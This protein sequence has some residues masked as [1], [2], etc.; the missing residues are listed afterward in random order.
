MR[1][2]ILALALAAVATPTVA[3]D[4]SGFYAGAT[5]TGTHVSGPMDAHTPWN[6]YA[7]FDLQG[8]S[9]TG[10]GGGV[11]LGF[12]VQ[13]S[14]M[15]YG[16]EAGWG[17]AN[18]SA[19]TTT[20]NLRPDFPRFDRTL[21]SVITLTPRVG[22][23]SGDSLFYLRGGLAIGRFGSAHDQHGTDIIGSTSRT[24]WLVGVGVDHRLSADMSLRAGVDYMNFG[25]FRTDIP[26]SPDIYT[27]QTARATRFGL[28]VT[29]HFN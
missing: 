19:S 15:V 2:H 24:G 7:G 9:G 27:I 13:G 6:G 12:N 5:L 21:G 29:W 11:H 10:L 8:V 1:R 3:Q 18:F 23:V 20:G 28:G 17:H 16:I 14:G 26:G 25:E 22:L 4:W